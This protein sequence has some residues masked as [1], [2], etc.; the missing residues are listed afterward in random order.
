M[1]YKQNKTLSKEIFIMQDNTSDT[2][3]AILTLICQSSI[4]DFFNILLNLLFLHIIFKIKNKNISS[5]LNYRLL[6]TFTFSIIV[7]LIS[8]ITVL[9]RVT[10]NKLFND[11]LYVFFF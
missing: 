10:Y 2:L 11:L 7:K 1:I 6:M 3:I 8:M 5:Y 9:Y 4:T